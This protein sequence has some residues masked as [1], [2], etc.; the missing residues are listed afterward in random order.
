MPSFSTG[1]A[2]PGG[3]N[4]KSEPRASFPPFGGSDQRAS[5]LESKAR[6]AMMKSIKE[7]Y[8]R[9][10]AEVEVSKLKLELDAEED[11]ARGQRSQDRIYCPTNQVKAS[12]AFL[13][14]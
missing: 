2:S 5:E 12:A 7:R 14:A 13:L 3:R 4:K 11:E 9:T 10:K 1:Q 6:E 8:D